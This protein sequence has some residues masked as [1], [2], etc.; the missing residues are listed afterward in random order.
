MW[1]L[2]GPVSSVAAAWGGALSTLSLLG[3]SEFLAGL[4]PK[5]GIAL[6]FVGSV[7]RY[8]ILILVFAISLFTEIRVPLSL[9]GGLFLWIPSSILTYW[10]FRK[11]SESAL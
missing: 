3:L 11:R 9:I 10:I 8:G 2:E 1:W 7:L 6:V 5:K 4:V